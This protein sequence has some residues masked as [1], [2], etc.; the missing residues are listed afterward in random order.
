MFSGETNEDWNY[1]LLIL[2][3]GC[4]G[5]QILFTYMYKKKKKTGKKKN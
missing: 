2:V 3:S 5:P 1:F 4:M